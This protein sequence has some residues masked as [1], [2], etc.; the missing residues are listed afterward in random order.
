MVET[1]SFNKKTITI[2]GIGI[3]LN[4]PKKESWWGDLSKFNFADK[5]EILISEIIN[6]FI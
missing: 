1:E 5:R 4:L 2:I 6:G 3:N